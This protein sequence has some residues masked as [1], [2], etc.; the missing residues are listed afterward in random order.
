MSGSLVRTQVYQLSDPDGEDVAESYPVVGAPVG[1]RALP[2]DLIA[3]S[4]LHLFFTSASQSCLPRI[5]ETEIVHHKP[6]SGH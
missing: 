3:E 1:P 4:T 6:L 2:L 5:K